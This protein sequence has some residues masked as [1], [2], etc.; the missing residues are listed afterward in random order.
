[1]RAAST[2]QISPRV[3]VCAALAALVFFS[4]GW[5]VA[6]GGPP[7]PMWDQWDVEALGLYQPWLAST[8]TWEQIAAP[9]N[10]H[11]LVLTRLV[12]LALLGAT[13]EWTLWPQ[14]ALNALLDTACAVLV[15]AVLRPALPSRL[16]AVLAVG[17]ALIF[18]VPA[19]CQSPLRGIDSAFYFAKFLAVAAFAAFATGEPFRPRWWL[20]VMATLLALGSIASGALVAV[21]VAGISATILACR[22]SS[23]KAWATMAVTL[24]IALAAAWLHAPKAEHAVGRA[25]SLAQFVTV[26]TRCL[27]WPHVAH[28]LAWLVLQLPLA[29]LLLDLRRRRETPGPAVH[30]AVLL[31]TFA[32]LNAAAAA[33]ARGGAMPG[34]QPLPRY[35]HPFM[36]GAAAQLFALCQLAARHGR[37][38]RLALL[39]WCGFASVGL[40]TLS[41]SGLTEQLP[42]VRTLHRVSHEVARRFVVSGDLAA[43]RREARY[44]VLHPDPEIPARVL[45]DPA[46]RPILPRSLRLGLDDPRAALPWWVRHAALLTALSS[47]LFAATLAW[48][49][50]PSAGARP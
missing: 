30:F 41:I 16:G 4:R 12:D 32:M 45:A 13:G 40:C 26:A 43:F 35:H 8:L 25:G 14:I 42:Y 3:F 33:Y 34:E 6:H 7:V 18:I 37:P 47:A 23:K 44:P 19:D 36:L 9:H 38:G 10:E 2:A 48:G 50:K 27:A 1:M 5:L 17:V 22:G 21:A 20:G 24:A 49:P 46:L 31:A 11:R 39:G 28:G 15:L 29:W